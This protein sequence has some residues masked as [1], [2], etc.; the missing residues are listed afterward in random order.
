MPDMNSNHHEGFLALKLIPTVPNAA[1]LE[2]WGAP[3]KTSL[4]Q[5]ISKSSN[6]AR[7]TTVS[8]SV[9]NRAPAIQP[10]QRS[11]TLFASSGTGLDTRISAI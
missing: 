9:S 8:S 4:R 2:S 1:A 7:V 11:M 6:P 3:A 5:T 10:V